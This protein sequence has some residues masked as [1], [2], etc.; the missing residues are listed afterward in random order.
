MYMHQI[1]FVSIGI[2]P[3]V[4]SIK[5][6]L[7]VSSAQSAHSRTEVEEQPNKKPK[8]GED[9]SAVAIVK[10]AVANGVSQLR[11]VSQD[12]EPPDSA[13]NSRKAQKCWNQFDEYDSRGLHCVKQTSEKIKVRHMV[14]YKSGNLRTILQDRL[15]DKSD[16]FAEMRGNLPWK[17]LSSKKEDKATFYSHF[18]ESIL[19][20]A[21]TKN[22]REKE[23][24]VDPG[25]SR[26]IV[27][28]KDLNKAELETVKIL[29]NPIMVVTANGEVLAR[30]KATV[31]LFENTRAV[32]PLGKL[33][34]AFGYRQ[35]RAQFR[36]T[37]ISRIFC[38]K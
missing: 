11:C 36:V 30:N 33:F 31:M 4:N 17:S 27:C 5:R 20:A 29:K 23:F 28:K 16:A 10:S 19:P 2:L 26:H 38:F 1:A 34:E 24:V 9:K 35:H 37:L 22:N 32:L 14:K 18:E 12:T 7:D 25:A 6:N 21:S 8:K 13:T 3:N 15:Q